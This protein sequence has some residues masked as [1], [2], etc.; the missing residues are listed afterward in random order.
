[1]VAC[2]FGA[3]STDFDGILN[4][5]EKVL[6][7]FFCKGSDNKYFNLYSHMVSVGAQQLCSCSMKAATENV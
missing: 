3:G 5:T 4:S 1:M 7:Y 6:V 2:L